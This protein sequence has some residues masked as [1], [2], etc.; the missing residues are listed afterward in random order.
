M[1]TLIEN[2]LVDI[3][4]KPDRASFSDAKSSI[5]GLASTIGKTVLV[6]KGL[7]A[8]FTGAV[9]GVARNLSDLDKSSRRLGITA[10]ELDKLRYIADQT[11]TPFNVLER[12]LNNLTRNAADVAKEEQARRLKLSGNWV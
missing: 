10:T 8:A 3:G 2:F 11:S 6:V 5:A 7:Q 9:I 4:I 12:S 1:A